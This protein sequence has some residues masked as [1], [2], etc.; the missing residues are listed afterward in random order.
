MNA[1]PARAKRTLME[2]GLKIV[3]FARAGKATTME[4]GHYEFLEAL[5]IDIRVRIMCRVSLRWPCNW[6]TVKQKKNTRTLC[7]IVKQV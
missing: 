7:L 3:R 2:N 6:Q 4:N 1:P 5:A